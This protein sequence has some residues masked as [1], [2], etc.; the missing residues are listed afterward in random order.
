MKG[1]LDFM[2]ADIGRAV[3]DFAQR[4]LGGNLAEDAK[5]VLERLVPRMSEVAGASDRTYIRNVLPYRTEDNR[6]DGVVTFTE[7]TERK[8]WKQEVQAAREFAESIVAT[9]RAPLLVLT[10]DLRVRSATAS[11]YRTYQASPEE[12]VDRPIYE[13]RNRQWD[14]PQL[15]RLLDE[16]LPADKQFDEFQVEHEFE[17]IGRRTM[18]LNARRLEAAQLILLAIEDITERKRSEDHKELL[19]RELSHR[20]KNTLAVIQVLATQTNG[21][22]SVK[23]FRESFVGRLHAMA[24]THNLLLDAEWRGTELQALVEQALG[25]LPARPAGGHG[26]RGRAGAADG[27]PGA[28]AQPDPARARNQRCQARRAVTSRRPRAPLLPARGWQPPPPRP[29][30]LAG[31]RRFTSPT[32]G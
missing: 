21:S 8:H 26:D 28:E 18:L 7:I 16:V 19:A 6:I 17:T 2:P 1:L 3:S 22:R 25:P 20:V 15:R 30:A 32:A 10:P 29:P 12:T 23:E 13:L 14:I 24:R 9:V 27:E 4:F 5:E 11:F 31:A